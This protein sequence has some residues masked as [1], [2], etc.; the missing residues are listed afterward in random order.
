MA[1][2]ADAIHVGAQTVLR[3]RLATS[4]GF[5]ILGLSFAIWAVHIATIAER[6]SL[7][8]AILG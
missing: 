8:P 2:S 1:A 3:A 6:L 4:I 7:D 5:F